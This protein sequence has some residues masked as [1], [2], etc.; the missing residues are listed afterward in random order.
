MKKQ[1]RSNKGTAEETVDIYWRE[2][3]SSDP[4][5]SYEIRQKFSFS[6]SFFLLFPHAPNC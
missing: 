5:A 1:R 2:I 4:S 3:L 6:F